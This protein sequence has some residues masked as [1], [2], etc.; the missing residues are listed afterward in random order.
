MGTETRKAVMEH[1][2]QQ[3]NSLGFEFSV[4]KGVF[5]QCST[6][7]NKDWEV[8]FNHLVKFKEANGHCNVPTKVSTL[9]RWV[10][11]KGRNIVS[12]KPIKAIKIVN[13]RR[14]WLDSFKDWKQLA[15][16]FILVKGEGKKRKKKEK[17]RN[18]R[19]ESIEQL[20]GI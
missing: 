4:G 20:E 6:R 13:Q 19:T 12:V 14:N 16:L 5:S 3:L 15:F 8:Q 10:A 11:I 17:K 18:S 1:R 2:I 7:N 9:G